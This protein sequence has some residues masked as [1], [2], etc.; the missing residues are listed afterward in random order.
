MLY[1]I[2]NQTVNSKYVKSYHKALVN[3]SKTVSIGTCLYSDYT[4]CTMCLNAEHNAAHII[5]IKYNIGLEHTDG[6]VLS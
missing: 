4:A 2:T 1:T 6:H 5:E 3:K